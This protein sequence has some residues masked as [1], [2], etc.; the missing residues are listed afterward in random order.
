MSLFQVIFSFKGQTVPLDAVSTETTVDELYQ[1][2]RQALSLSETDPI[3]ILYKGKL[4]KNE[5]VSV[6]PEVPRKTPRLM[7]MAS[8]TETVRQMNAKRSDSPVSY[9]RSR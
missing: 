4:L 2:V 5:E 3:K 1:R 9:T 8:S 6:F 7:V